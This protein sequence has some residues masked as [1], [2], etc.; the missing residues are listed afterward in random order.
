MKKEI[1]FMA[2]TLLKNTGSFDGLYD[3]ELLALDSTTVETRLL[4]AITATKTAD[5]DIWVNG[6]LTYTILV[7]NLEGM[8]FITPAFTDILD[9]TKIGFVTNSFLV[10]GAVYAHDYTG[11]TLTATLPT[12]PAGGQLTI[13]FTVYKV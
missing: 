7:N 2:E 1:F 5:R 9:T 13:A 12:I 8:D 11:G 6:F 10:D 4:S 3:G